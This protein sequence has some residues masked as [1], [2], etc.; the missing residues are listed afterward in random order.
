MGQYM[1]PQ[2]FAV[3]EVPEPAEPI[4]FAALSGKGSDD[5]LSHFAEDEKTSYPEIETPAKNETVIEERATTVETA[6]PENQID[7]NDETMILFAPSPSKKTSEPVEVSDNIFGDI[8]PE[9]AFAH[10]EIFV[11]S[12]QDNQGLMDRFERLCSRLDARSNRIESL[13]S[14]L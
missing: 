3:T 2:V 12:E 1:Q 14:G 8:A 13:M 4:D 6:E 11:S 7:E 10:F 9:K 5:I